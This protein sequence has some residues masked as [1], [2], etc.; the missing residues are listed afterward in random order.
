MQRQIHRLLRRINHLYCSAFWTV[1]VRFMSSVSF[2]SVVPYELSDGT[3]K[4]ILATLRNGDIVI[5]HPCEVFLA[6]WLNNVWFQTPGSFT[7]L[8][9]GSCIKGLFWNCYEY[10]YVPLFFVMFSSCLFFLFVF[11]FISGCRAGKNRE[12]SKVF[13]WTEKQN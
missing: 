8:R 10:I 2:S 11:F 12:K 13:Y 4:G 1:S 6:T 7:S 3:W 5:G 9:T